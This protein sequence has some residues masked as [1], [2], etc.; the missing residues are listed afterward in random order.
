MPSG[1]FPKMT[2]LA[3]RSVKP[4]A[5]GK[6]RPSGKS[7][8]GL[9][10]RP[11]DGKCC[12]VVIAFADIFTSLL[13]PSGQMVNDALRFFLD[14]DDIVLDCLLSLPLPGSELLGRDNLVVACRR[15]CETHRCAHQEQ[16]FCFS[17]AAQIVRASSGGMMIL[18][19]T[20]E[21]RCWK[22]NQAS[23]YSGQWM[24]SH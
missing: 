21:R 10:D 23:M 5:L 15:E 7:R 13:F 17:L 14:R 24:L 18:V 1:T 9:I 6:A 20:D 11:A 8:L 3:S 16:L 4:N 19:L 12:H 22:R 2:S